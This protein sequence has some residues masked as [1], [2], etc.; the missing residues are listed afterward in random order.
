M[1]F[2]SDLTPLNVAEEKQRFFN[3]FS[4]NPQFVYNREFTKQELTQWGLPNQEMYQ[5]ALSMVE[6][7]P[8]VNQ[9][10][11]TAVTQEQVEKKISQL[12]EQLGIPDTLSV[13]FEKNRITSCG[14]TDTAIKFRIPLT[15]SSSDLEA[16]L[17]HEIETHFLRKRNNLQQPWA[18]KTR[19][20]Y[21]FRS[22]EE[23][24]AKLHG[25]L[26]LEDKTMKQAFYTYVA[27]Y[28]A[29]TL[30]FS[31]LFAQ[32]MDLGLWQDRA[33]FVTLVTKRGLTDTSQP[34]G[35]TKTVTYIQGA[36]RVLKW[37]LSQSNDPHQ[38]YWGR[39]DINEI[40]HLSKVAIKDNLLFPTFFA[41][42]DDYQNKILEICQA[43]N[44]EK[45]L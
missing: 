5:H 28:L 21:L 42:M 26:H 14:I 30:S 7:N 4:Y 15:Y 39:I 1:S 29:Q 38:L 10:N 2:I 40:E 45:F 23:G 22:T 8:I 20:D 36:L 13:K 24:L 34:G 18:S 17:G 37:I 44:F 19:P 9:K 33:W 16:V 11:K 31:Q 25:Y 43:N 41:D 6:K 27:V 12:L 3:D 35:I 32:L